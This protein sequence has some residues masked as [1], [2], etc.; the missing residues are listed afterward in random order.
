MTLQTDIENAVNQIKQ[1]SV[2]FNNIVHGDKDTEVTTDNG[3]VKTVAKAIA[4]LENRF[5]ES[6]F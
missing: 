4:D 1:D 6:E 2:K 3:S 5:N